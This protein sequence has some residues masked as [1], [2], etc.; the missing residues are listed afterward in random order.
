MSGEIQ[1]LRNDVNKVLEQASR[2]SGKEASKKRRSSNL[3]RFSIAALQLQMEAEPFAK[4]GSCLVYRA[5]YSNQLVC[6][7]V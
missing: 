2:L 6:A 1:S 4:G 7:K 3:E 5:K